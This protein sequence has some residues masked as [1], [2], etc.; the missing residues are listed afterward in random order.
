MKRFFADIYKYA[1][2]VWFSAVSELKSEV[3]GSYLNWMWWILDP[4][5]F[6]VIYAF[7]SIVV[8]GTTEQYFPVFVIIGLTAWTFFQK[9]CDSSVTVVKYNAG[10]ITK[11]YL[12]KFILVLTK[13]VNAFIKMLISLAIA[14]AAALV[15]KVPFNWGML[16]VIPILIVM[17]VFTFGISVWLMHL[18]V[19]AADLNNVT[20]I[21]L[22][23]MFYLSGV[24]FSIPN[25]IPPPYGTYA[26]YLNPI[27]LI[28]NELRSALIYQ[29]PVH[30][31]ALG[32]WLLVGI[33]WSIYAVHLVYKNE[34]SYVKVI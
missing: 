27:A 14:L 25:Q 23:L 24:F 19:F 21:V 33:V 1:H 6:T 16:Q 13:M 4:L 8:Y 29:T 32:A 11:L 18:G 12:P 30:Y 15:W 26:L 22:R 9:C 3:A 10:L 7:V 28:I 31:L 2:Y 34:N 17:F 20:T 5:C